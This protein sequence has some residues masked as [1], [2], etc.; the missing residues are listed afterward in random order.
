MVHKLNF[1]NTQQVNS[2]GD[3]THNFP[4]TIQVPPQ[5]PYPTTHSSSEKRQVLAKMSTFNY[6]GIKGKVLGNIVS[7]HKSFVGRDYKALS[8][9]ALFVF[10]P[11]LS[12]G[13]RKVWLALSK[14]HAH[15]RITS[16]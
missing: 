13:E 7:Y 2:C 1:A 16:I 3:T 12:E 8:Q 9:I 5:D 15:V 10:W 4:W 14:V 6:S 11:Y